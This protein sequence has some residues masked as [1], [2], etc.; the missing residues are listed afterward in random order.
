MRVLDS[1]KQEEK[2]E[3]RR[4]LVE[5]SSHLYPQVGIDKHEERM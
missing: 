1:S 4:A 2:R 3:N 5:E